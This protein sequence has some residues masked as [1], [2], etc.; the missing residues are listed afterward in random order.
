MSTPLADPLAAHPLAPHPGV[1]RKPPAIRNPWLR[2]GLLLAACGYLVAAL[3]SLPIDVERV[4]RG[5]A[6]IRDMLVA[7]VTPD[8][9]TRGEAIANGLLES[10]AMTIAA[11]VIGVALSI[12]IGIC[13]ARNLCGPWLRWPCRAL[14]AVSRAFHELIVAIILVKL[15]GF[16][17]LAGVI[18]LC[19]ATIGFFSKLLADA[20][21]ACHPAPL[22]AI[23]A[24]GANWFQVVAY[25]VLPQVRPRM[26]GLAL[27][28]L[29]INF[30]ESAILGVV[31][32]GG[33]GAT[34]M[35]AVDR[36]DFRI[37]AA[38][39]LIII[40]LVLVAEFVSG[41]IRRRLV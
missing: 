38:I 3:A 8:F 28:R 37:A 23:R 7:F 10:I 20:I 41:V 32:A 13:A 9:A 16:G 26:I 18:T 21:E 4:L 6:Y 19:F 39:L 5:T 1:W 2:Y 14:I 27:Y 11:T 22:E 33:I 25:A 15:L 34:L 31:G 36:F 29:D 12:P 17:M 24:T 40:V 30:R 35:T